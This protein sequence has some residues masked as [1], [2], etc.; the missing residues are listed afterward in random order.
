MID[1][2][3]ITAARALLGLT[4]EELADRA[5]LTVPAIQALEA[6]SGRIDDKE[7]AAT[8][9]RAALE[10]AGINFIEER[11]T[12]AAGGVGVRLAVPSASVDIDEQQ[13]VQYPEMA[14]NGP[15]GA[16]G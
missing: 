3:Q 1:P 15:F 2:R 10:D 14:T 13:T 4:Q 6:G 8:A 12:S 11:A 9:V 16:G 7:N 5:Q